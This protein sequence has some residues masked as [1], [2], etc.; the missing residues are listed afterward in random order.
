M[1]SQFVSL[2]GEKLIEKAIIFDLDCTLHDREKSLYLFLNSQYDRLLSNSTSISFPEFYREFVALEQFGH[3]WKDVVYDEL[4]LMYPEI[5][6]SRNELL[7]DYWNHFSEHC[8]CFE[9]TIN[10]LSELKNSQ[11]KLGMITNGKTDFQK[12]TIHALKL[13]EFFDDIIIS[14]EIGLKKPDGR[15]FEASLHNLKVSEEQAIYI[16]D[17]PAHDIKAAGDVGLHTIWKRNDYWGNADT[18]YSFE[19]MRELPSL[20]EHIFKQ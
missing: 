6:L 4:L 8:V 15:I 1:E 2:G 20:I 14:E 7:D 9:G 13:A 3:K 5:N 17:H 12:A 16:G 19:S 10:M 11:Y 18:K